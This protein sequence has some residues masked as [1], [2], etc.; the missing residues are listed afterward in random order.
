MMARSSVDLPQPL[1]PTSANI[2]PGCTVRLT[3][4]CTTLLPKRVFRSRISIT[5]AVS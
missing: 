3:L 1:P 4:S 5:A 2:S